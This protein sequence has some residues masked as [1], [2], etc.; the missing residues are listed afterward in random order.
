MVDLREDMGK[1]SACRKTLQ[2][3]N[4]WCYVHH[5]RGVIGTLLVDESSLE[6]TIKPFFVTFH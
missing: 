5:E 3:M 4:L 1:L 2:F 6:P